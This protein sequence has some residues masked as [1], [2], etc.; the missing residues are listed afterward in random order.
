MKYTPR[1]LQTTI[2]NYVLAHP[3]CA[4]W[5]FMGSGKTSAILSVLEKLHFLGEITDPV[6]VIA[7]L[8]VA[9][10][11][12]PEEVAKFDQFRDIVCLPIL[13]HASQREEV[14]RRFLPREGRK[15]R[16]LQV[17]TIN[18]ENIGWLVDKL[19]GNWPFRTIVA[20]EST[21]LKGYRKTQ[22]TSRARALAQIAWPTKQRPTHLV[23]RFIELTG[24]PSPNGLQDLWG[25]LWFVD[26]GRRL[27][28]SY[29]AFEGRWFTKG[30]DGFSTKPLPH[31]QKEMDF[32]L[33]DCCLS[34]KAEDYFDLEKPIVNP[35][36][37]DLPSKARTQ[38]R[39]LE[40]QMYTQIENTLGEKHEIEAFSAATMTLKCLQ[41]ASGAMYV[42]GDNKEWVETHDIKIEALKDVVE[43]AAGMPVLVAYHFRSTLAR[44]MRAFPRGRHLDKDPQTITD[45]NAGRIPVLFAHP[46]SAGHGINLQYGGNT[47]VFF[48][49]WWDLEQF[50]QIGERIGPVRQLQAGLHRP[51]FI[52]HLIARGTL[53]ETVMLRRESKRTVQDLLLAAV[54]A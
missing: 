20:D 27:G 48:D 50:Q 12:W 35:I 8:R 25:Q 39:E 5:S 32:L 29:S 43:E 41:M 15:E 23:D 36:Y 26:G 7:P 3:R 9:K 53:D 49:H 38:Y 42:G 17:F 22:G 37:V 28:S 13:G 47:L 16:R 51:V 33:K 18:Y 21:K 4:I 40:K 34:L 19:G 6:L 1:P 45:W 10:S 30:Y 31:A 44:L 54:K 46:A 11:T 2:E 14:L 24:T 52:H